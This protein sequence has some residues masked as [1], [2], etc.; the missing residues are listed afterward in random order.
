MSTPLGLWPTDRGLSV[1]L[2][3]LPNRARE[4]WPI[5]KILSIYGPTV[6]LLLPL[7]KTRTGK[8]A[9]AGPN[10]LVRR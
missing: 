5:V 1:V 9:E 8:H 6:L 7:E 4:I 10:R 3:E 2:A